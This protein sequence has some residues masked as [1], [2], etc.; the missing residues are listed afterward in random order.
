MTAW[1]CQ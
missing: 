1:S